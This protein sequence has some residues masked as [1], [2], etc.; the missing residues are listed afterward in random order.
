MGGKPIWTGN[1][2]MGGKPIWTEN[3]RMGGKRA[4]L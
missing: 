1:G 2:R 3:G 4:L